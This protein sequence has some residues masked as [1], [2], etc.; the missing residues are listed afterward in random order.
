MPLRRDRVEDI[1]PG[2][3]WLMRNYPTAAPPPRLSRRG[4]LGLASSA[5]GF[6]PALAWAGPPGT[7]A[8][9]GDPALLSP[10]ER[11]HLPVLQLPVVT[12]NGAKVP[13]V[14]EMTHPMTP[15]H[16]IE[17]I[18]VVNERD[19]SPSKG[20]FYLTPASGRV[21]LATTANNG[22]CGGCIQV[23]APQ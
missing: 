18:P 14:V 22:P 19:P 2:P 17:S 20:M 10:F 16:H 7:R 12:T 21:Y 15:D 23:F 5:V 13:I 4:F 3:G 6:W 9:A 8:L 11:E 1:E